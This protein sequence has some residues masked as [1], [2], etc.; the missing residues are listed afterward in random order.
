MAAHADQSG[1]ALVDRHGQRAAQVNIYHFVSNTYRDED[2]P[3][4][5]LSKLDA[6]LEFL[7]RAVKKID[8]IREDLG[9]VGPVIAE[10]VE[11][12]M[13]GHERSLD[14]RQ[15]EANSPARRLHA[16]ERT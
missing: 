12:A 4:R 8:R 1:W 15:A 11:K 9:N 14:T 5:S 10:R 6:D 2:L 13:L 16:F 7:M 3:G